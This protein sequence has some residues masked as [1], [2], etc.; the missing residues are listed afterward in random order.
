MSTN[1][2]N[3]VTPAGANP[4]MKTDWFG[5]RLVKKKENNTIRIG[6]QNVGNIPKEPKH[7]KSIKLISSIIEKD[8][9]IFGMAETGLDWFNIDGDGQWR[10]RTW[11]KFSVSKSIMSWNRSEDNSSSFLPGGTGI[12]H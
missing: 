2:A 5:D 6:F 10:E 11:D 12:S 7:P 9:D 3:R 4:N 8:F 1:S